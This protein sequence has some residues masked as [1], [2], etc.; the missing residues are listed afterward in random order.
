MAP[1][2]WGA[3]TAN[4][5]WCEENYKYTPYIAEFF[6]TLTS[7]TVMLVGL[8][9]TRLSLRHQYGLSFLLAGIGLA[10]VGL[11]SIVFHGT[12][13]REGQILDEVPMLWSSLIFFW[14]ALSLRMTPEKARIYAGICFG[15]GAI[16]TYIYLQG[17]FEIFITAYIATIAAVTITTG[18]HLRDIWA[19]PVRKTVLPY[20]LGGL[21]F[22]VGGAVL[23]WVPEQLFCGNRLETNHD[24]I[25]LRLPVP[26]HA[27]FHLSSASIP[28]IIRP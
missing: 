18:L 28:S 20:I 17:G 21:V 11:G 6:N 9:F 13:L 3:P 14:I 1:G 5:D 23:L 12:L 24:S 2:F 27:W 4:Y 22:Y 8:L 10:V 16:S 26:L 25:L 15:Y 19:K 7:L